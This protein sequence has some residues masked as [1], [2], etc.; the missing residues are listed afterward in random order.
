MHA[1]PFTETDGAVMYKMNRILVSDADRI[2]L[3]PLTEEVMELNL[4]GELIRTIGRTGGGPG[5]YNSARLALY[6]KDKHIW[7]ITRKRV[8]HYYDNDYVDG[9]RLPIRGGF[10]HFPYGANAKSF[11]VVD[12]KI[13]LS[14]SESNRPEEIATL[15]S[16]EGKPLQ[17]AVDPDFPEHLMNLHPRSLR[18]Q[19]A[20]DNGKWYA[21]Y[22]FVPKL[23]VF[24]K[25]LQFESAYHL[26]SPVISAYLRQTEGKTKP[27]KLFWDF[28]IA[29]GSLWALTQRGLHRIDGGSVRA[30]YTFKVKGNP[31]YE[32][33]PYFPFHHFA[34]LPDGRII[35]GHNHEEGLFQAR[36]KK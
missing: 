28:K 6:A 31:E 33:A 19:W 29:G 30:L 1:T 2:F 26:T 18:T 34:L 35:L 17:V 12:G 10:A 22:D 24:N 32:A 5:E 7:L 14:A 21:L 23:I 25:D 16:P 27:M 36:L 15:Y 4:Q 20:Y 11:A 9:F 13:L 3:A 8:I